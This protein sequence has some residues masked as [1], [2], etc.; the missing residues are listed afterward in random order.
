MDI[1]LY[2]K[3]VISPTVNTREFPV[4]F[5]MAKFI[6]EH[7]LVQIEVKKFHRDILV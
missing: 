7:K 6:N 5:V 2:E 3:T 4:I 1:Q